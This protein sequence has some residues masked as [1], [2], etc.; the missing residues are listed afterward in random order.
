[1]ISRE[2]LAESLARYSQD[3]FSDEDIA[4][5]SGLSARAYRELIKLKAVRTVTERRGPG[6]VRICDNTNFKRIAVIA[7]LKSASQ[8]LAVS[9]RIA[10]FAPLHTLLYEVCDPAAIL[11][12]RPAGPGAN[13]VPPS[14]IAHLRSGWFDSK[15]PAKAEPE[16]WLIDIFD[17]RFVG[18]RYT[19]KEEPTIFG[20]LRDNNTCFVAWHPGRKRTRPSGPIFAFAQEFNPRAIEACRAWEDPTKWGKEFTLLGYGFERHDRNDDPL[21]IAAEAAIRSP[22][23]K[24]TVNIS[25]AIRKALRRYLGLQ[26]AL[27]D[28]GLS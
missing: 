15:T 10:F 5:C 20:D 14:A 25:L 19:E 2:T 3:Q 26:P 24:T 6:R 27:P 12:Q 17:N 13:D 9:G 1:M 16:D 23:V 18:I 8:N 21:C 22:L 11:H 7:A 28:A 4:R